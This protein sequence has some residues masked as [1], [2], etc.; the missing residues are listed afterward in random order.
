MSEQYTSYFGQ[1]IAEFVAQKRAVGWPYVSSQQR[2]TASV[3]STIL[4]NGN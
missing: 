4:T 3:S 2:L 1:N